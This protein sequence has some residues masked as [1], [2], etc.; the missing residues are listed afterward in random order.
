MTSRCFLG[1]C[2]ALFLFAACGKTNEDESSSAAGGGVSGAY[3]SGGSGGQTAG[4][5]GEAAGGS[6]GL[7]GASGT[8]AD[9]DAGDADGQCA[10]G[11]YQTPKGCLTCQAALAI[12]GDQA[13][14]ALT[15]AKACTVSTDCMI[16]PYQVGYCLRQCVQAIGSSNAAAFSAK[17]AEIA[18]GGYCVC[19]DDPWDCPDSGSAKTEC[20]SGSCQLTIPA[21]DAS[22]D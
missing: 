18:S 11:E 10:D 1:I 12:V 15:T 6:A 14:A 8:Q 3:P 17:L 22:T 4:N 21:P 20:I 7:D 9:V 2:A 19:P 13:Y 5:G 16:T